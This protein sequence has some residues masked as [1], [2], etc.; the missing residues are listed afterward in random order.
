LMENSLLMVSALRK[1]GVP[2]E[3]HLY[4]RGEHGLALANHLTEKANGAG[5]QEECVSWLQLVHVWIKNL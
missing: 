3:F 5:V 1:A 2:T 4:P